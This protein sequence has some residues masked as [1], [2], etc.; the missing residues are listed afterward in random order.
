MRFMPSSAAP[1]GD[2]PLRLFEGAQDLLTLG[3]F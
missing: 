3:F 1:L 2:A